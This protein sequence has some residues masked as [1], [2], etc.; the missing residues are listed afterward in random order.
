MKI[1]VAAKGKTVDDQVDDRFARAQNLI[2]VDT[3]T[4]DFEVLEN[5]Q[6]AQAAHGAGVQAAASI[7]NAGVEY[8]ITGHCGP[9]AFNILNEAGIKVVVGASG[10]V[11]EAVEAYKRGELKFADSSDVNRHW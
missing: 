4:M 2:I 1:A 10:T 6:N 8:V 11:K 3:D 5:A 9:N 7:A